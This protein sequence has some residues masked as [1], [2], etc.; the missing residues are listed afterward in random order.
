VR[1]TLLQRH[2]AEV[3]ARVEQIVQL[4]MAQRLVT[5][6]GFA[7]KPAFEKLSVV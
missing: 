1:P 4:K 7:V 5:A 2:A 3:R 6:P